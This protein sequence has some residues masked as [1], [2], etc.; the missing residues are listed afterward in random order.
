[1]E[2]TPI[3]ILHFAELEEVLGGEGAQVG[4]EIQ[5]DVA[6]ARDDQDRHPGPSPAAGEG[7]RRVRR[8]RGRGGEEE[9]GVRG[10]WGLERGFG[11]RRSAAEEGT[12]SQSQP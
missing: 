4:V 8:G 6:H 2:Q 9:A 1:M 11:R 3:V 7:R 10:R 12:P 5:L